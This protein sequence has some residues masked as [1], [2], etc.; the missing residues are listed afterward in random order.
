[1][2]LLT[3]IDRFLRKYHFIKSELEWYELFVSMIGALSGMLLISYLTFKGGY[4]MMA[5]SFGATCVL[6]YAMPDVPVAQPRNVILGHLNS[7]IMGVIVSHIFGINWIS[8]S[9]AVTLAIGLM[10]I[11]DTLHPPGGATALIAALN[12][13]GV[14]FIFTPILAGAVLL[15]L[16]AILTNKFSKNCHFAS[17]KIYIRTP[18]QIIFAKKEKII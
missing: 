6:I 2:E 3:F 18:L 7:A 12:G 5:P 13:Y 17:E 15:V 14:Q 4:P 1:M 11:T 9:F 8:V 16:I 10:Y